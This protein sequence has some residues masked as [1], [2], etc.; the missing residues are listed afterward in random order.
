VRTVGGIIIRTC[1]GTVRRHSS[2]VRHSVR[3]RYPRGAL[4]VAIWRRLFWLLSGS[5]STL[6]DAAYLRQTSAQQILNQLPRSA[7]DALV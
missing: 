1:G 2:H 6:L 4:W 3:T 7:R 5:L